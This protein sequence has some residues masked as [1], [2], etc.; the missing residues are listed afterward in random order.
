MKRVAGNDLGLTQLKLVFRSATR[1]SICRKPLRS[2]VVENSTYCVTPMSF[3]GLFSKQAADYAQYRPRYPDALFTFLASVAPEH[4]LA[5]D[6]ATGN[7]QAALSLTPYFKQVVATDANKQQI[8][9]S[10]PH[11][12]IRYQISRAEQSEIGDHS[13]D[14]VTVAQAIHWFDLD[15]FYTEV[16]RVLKPGGVLAAWAYSH[17]NVEPA[18]D[19]VLWQYS[20][21]IMGPYWSPRLQLVE[22]GYRSLPFPFEEVETPDFTIEAQWDLSG[23]VGFL[24]SWSATQS[25]IEA[26]G[27][28]PIQEI[29]EA[30]TEAWGESEQKRRVWWPLALRVGRIR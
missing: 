22:E 9:N 19:A 14:L 6:C 20:S 17:L 23:V 12:R 11:E 13:V 8:A 27:Y 2:S 25:F 26:R 15:A 30:L 1:F 16:R 21:E 28:H 5:W 10:V 24:N 29:E 18:I 3:E 4:E 7:G